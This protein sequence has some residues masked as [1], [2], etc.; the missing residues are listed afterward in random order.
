MA[1]ALSNTALQQLFSM[2]LCAGTHTYGL[3]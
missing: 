2:R 1:N 3:S